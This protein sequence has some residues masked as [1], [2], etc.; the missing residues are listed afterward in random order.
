MQTLVDNIA[1]GGSPDRLS[2]IYVSR[3]PPQWSMEGQL[4]TALRSM[5]SVKAALDVALRI[6]LWEDVIHCYHQLQ[7][8]HKAADV[9][10]MQIETKGE[11]PLLCCMLGDA[12][13]ELEHYHR[14]LE[15]SN[16]KSARAYRALGVYYYFRQEYEQA[17][18]N[19]RRS[20]ELNGYQL[21][22]LLRLGY[23]ATKIEDWELSAQTYRKYCSYESDVS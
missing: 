3:L 9:I 5:G 16:N 2:L 17:V 22:T 1:E 7:L 8:R 12:T 15:L 14:A 21:N 10:R 19:L 23:A 11:T 6:E 18:E 20:V 13:D 4:C